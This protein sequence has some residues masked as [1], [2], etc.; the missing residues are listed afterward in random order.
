M[1]TPLSGRDALDEPGIERLVEHLIG[2]GV[3]GLFLLGTTGEG[4]SLSYRLRWEFVSRVTRLAAGRV[5]VLVCISDTAF[6][7][8]VALARHASDCGA[9]AVVATNPYY[10][11][12]GQPELIEY[13]EA[14]V[15]ELR[16]PLFLYNMPA[17]TKVA[18]APATVRRLMQQPRIVGIKDSSG[19]LA[20]FDELLAM[21]PEREGWS[22]LM[23]PEELT[24]A[25]VQ[26][27]AHGGV[28]GGANLQPRLF[29][30]N[31]EAAAAGDR[32]RAA[33]VEEKVRKLGA[34]IYGVGSHAS[35]YI[36]GLKCALSLLGICD[37]TMALPFRRFA[38]AERAVIR[39]RL[40]ALG[41]L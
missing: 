39:E 33:I 35:S 23:G 3:H 7:E 30:E 25:V 21:A 10:F 13:F 14:L 19:D 20:Y 29:V 9:D 1:I 2:G 6:A 12:A 8:S 36:K 5:P 11:S 32:E 28:N 40:V 24:S 41:L 4:P 15:A 16:L 17:M 27:G 38:E 37:D 34:G 26:R 22:V 18:L 31:Y